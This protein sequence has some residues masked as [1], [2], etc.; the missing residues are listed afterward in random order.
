MLVGNAG[1]GKTVFVGDTL[2]NLSEDYLVSR[3]PF[4]Y[5]TTSAALQ[6]EILD[7]FSDE[8]VDKVISGIRNEVRGLGMVDS[9]ENCWKFFLARVRLQLKVGGLKARLAS[10]EAELQLRNHDAEALITKIGL[11]TER[12]S[13]EKAIADAEEQKVAAIQIEVSQKQRECEADLLKAE[14][15]LVAA[16]GALNTL[17]RVKMTSWLLG[18]LNIIFK[19]Y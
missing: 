16:T 7:L 18:F 3:V 10:Q 13:R 17:N 2:T 12:V 4:N 6:R 14:P 5:Y 8:D 9:K 1:V 11:Q 15:A 19:G